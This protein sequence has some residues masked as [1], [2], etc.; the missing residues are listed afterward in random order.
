MKICCR[1]KYRLTKGKTRKPRIRDPEGGQYDATIFY[2][3]WWLSLRFV[4]VLPFVLKTPFRVSLNPLW[5]KIRV[6]GV[7]SSTDHYCTGG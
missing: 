4:V 5:V 7:L 6:I 2:G 3:S 1:Q